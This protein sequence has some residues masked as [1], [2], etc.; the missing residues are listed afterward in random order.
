MG[1]SGNVRLAPQ[2]SNQLGEVE[3]GLGVALIL[4]VRPRR[5]EGLEADEIVGEFVIVGHV[6]RVHFSSERAVAGFPHRIPFEGAHLP[7]RTYHPVKFPR[8][9]HPRP[10]APAVPSFRDSTFEDLA[11]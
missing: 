7:R 5:T 9:S 6:L 8:T 1:M 11:S 10:V 4:R 2:K 3:A